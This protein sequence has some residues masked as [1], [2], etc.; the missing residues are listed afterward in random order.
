MTNFDGLNKETSIDEDGGMVVV[1]YIDDLLIATRGSI[2]K[3]RK[4]VGKVFDLLLKNKLCLEID[5]CVFDATEVSYLGFIVNGKELKMDRKKAED[6]VNWPRPT[7]QQEVEQILELWNFYRRFTPNYAQI[8]TPISDLVSG[9]GKDFVFGEVQKAAFL[10]I[11]ILFTSDAMPIMRH[12]NQKRPAM[13]ETDVSDFAI[14]A[15]L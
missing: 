14:G 5:K 9:T 7:N 10:K 15:I 11:T 2:Q 13:T 1:A 12:F 8:V 4:Q 3:H 6:I